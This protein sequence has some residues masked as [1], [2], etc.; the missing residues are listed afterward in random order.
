MLQERKHLLAIAILTAGL[1]F[2][3]GSLAG[4]PADPG[5]GQVYREDGQAQVWSAAKEA[6]VSPEVFW[7][8]YVA[9]ADGKYWG[10][11]AEYPPYKEVNEH[12]TLIIEVDGGPCLMYFF[13]KRWRRAQD[14]RRWDPQFND[15][16]GCPNVFR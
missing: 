9:T 8:D 16:A 10:R 12:D 2:T 4:P 6:W 7:E 14:V 13:H 11:G 15:M 3:T 1:G 5:N